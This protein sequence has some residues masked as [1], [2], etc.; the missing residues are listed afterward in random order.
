MVERIERI[1]DEWEV[2]GCESGMCVNDV[3][4]SGEWR[5]EFDLCDGE[6]TADVKLKNRETAS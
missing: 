5:V 2:E 3:V 1:C 6:W 4:E